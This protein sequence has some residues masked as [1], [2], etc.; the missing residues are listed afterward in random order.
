MAKA[1]KAVQGR[2]LA[3]KVRLSL[4][5]RILGE[6]KFYPVYATI[7]ATASKKFRGPNGVVELTKPIFRKVVSVGSVNVSVMRRRIEGTMVSKI[8]THPDAGLCLLNVHVTM[9]LPGV[10]PMD[11][12]MVEVGVGVTSLCEEA[13]FDVRYKELLG[14]V[15]GAV[16]N[17]L[18]DV[19]R[20]CGGVP[21]F[22]ST[23][24]AEAEK[25]AGN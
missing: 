14:I 22:S 18:D 24:V 15:G 2:G 20:A 6:S 23:E 7:T 21:P 10:V 17:S 8:T 19:A 25:K 13:N 16:Q 3:N 4:R 11:Y 9:K 5:N 1:R 12:G